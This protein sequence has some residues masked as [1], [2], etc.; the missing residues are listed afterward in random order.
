MENRQQPNIDIKQ[1][2]AVV[3]KEGK[4]IILAGGITFRKGSRFLLGTDKDP[5]IPIE[6]MY[7]ISNNKILL[8]M[9]SPEIRD[10]YKEV[11]FSIADNG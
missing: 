4:P 5:L 9:I 11:G 6:I 10:E 7:D 2:A 8:D 3:D 1:T